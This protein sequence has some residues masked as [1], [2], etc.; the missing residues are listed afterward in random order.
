MYPMKIIVL[1]NLHEHSLRKILMLRQGT[2]ATA[3]KGEEGDKKVSRRYRNR[4]ILM[5]INQKRSIFQFQ[6]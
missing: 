1:K 6:M 4:R 2:L 5:K 3:K